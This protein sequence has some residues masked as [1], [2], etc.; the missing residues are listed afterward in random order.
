MDFNLSPEQAAFQ[1]EVKS[2]VSTLPG[3][4]TM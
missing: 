1:K 4:P 3:S 2:F